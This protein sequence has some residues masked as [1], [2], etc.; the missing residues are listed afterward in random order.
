[1]TIHLFVWFFQN[2]SSPVCD[3]EIV[4]IDCLNVKQRIDDTFIDE[5]F[6]GGNE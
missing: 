3:S 2:K 6:N 5:R 4:Y 1:M